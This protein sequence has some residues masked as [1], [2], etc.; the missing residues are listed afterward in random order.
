MFMFSMLILR[1]PNSYNL[2]AS[3]YKSIWLEYWFILLWPIVFLGRFVKN[4]CL[5]NWYHPRYFSK[6]IFII[7]NIK[8]L[9]L[10][11][12][13][14]NISPSFFNQI[15]TPRRLIQITIL[16]MKV[17]LDIHRTSVSLDVRFVGGLYCEYFPKIIML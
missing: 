7:I 4:F 3:S 17:W 9:I 2:S 10:W 15:S 6:K 16:T 12:I 13:S 8:F 5:S 1:T 14:L 11:L